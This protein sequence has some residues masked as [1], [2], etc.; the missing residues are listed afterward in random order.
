MYD[1]ELV[2]ELLNQIL[3][4]AH[5]IER[6]FGPIQTA[7]DFL[8]SDEGL[9]H[10]DG[11]AMM[12]IVIGESVKNL[13]KATN[14]TLLHALPRGGLE[15][16]QG[17]PGCHQSSLYGSECRGDFRHLPD[18]Y[19]ILDRHRR[20]DAAGDSGLSRCEKQMISVQVVDKGGK[21]VIV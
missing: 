6:R 3:V 13:D 1:D 14:G 9:D 4:A 7:N 16:R 21:L 8:S 5:R 12:L 20:K 15:G 2:A 19:S 11:I 18:V 17:C 10:L